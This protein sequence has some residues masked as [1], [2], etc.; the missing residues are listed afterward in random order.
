ML[1]TLL[2]AAGAFFVGARVVGARP[3]ASE[4][5]LGLD[6]GERT[7]D[8][9]VDR[10][11]VLSGASL[12]LAAGAV[13]V[14]ALWVGSAGLSLALCVPLCGRAWHALVVERRLRAAVLD[15]VSVVSSLIVGS[16]VLAAT[17]L[18]VIFGADHLQNRTEFRARRGLRA[19]DRPTRAWLRYGGADIEVPVAEL[20]PG[21]R[22]IVDAGEV[23]PIDGVVREGAAQV[24]ERMWT[25]ESLHIERGPG[26]PVFAGTRVVHGRVT[27]EVTRAGAHAPVSAP[28]ATDDERVRAEPRGDRMADAAVKPT[29]AVAGLAGLVGGG[30]SLSAAFNSNY[31]DNMQ[32]AVPLALLRA[33]RRAIDRHILV[34]D[35]RAFDLLAAV[36]A[37]VVDAQGGSADLFAPP[38]DR[39]VAVHRGAADPAGQVDRLRAEGRR[40]CYVGADAAALRRADVAVGLRDAS[41]G[42]PEA[43]HVVLM[44]GDL[45]ELPALFDLV[46]DYDAGV[47]RGVAINLACTVVAGGGVL[48]MRLGTTGVLALYNLSLALSAV[49]AY[50]PTPR[51]GQALAGPYAATR[52]AAAAQVVPA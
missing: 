12:G 37:V 28:D 25:G 40:V 52:D 50:I 10:A 6:D 48:L 51:R 14:P 22:V 4:Q 43:A 41:A 33:H 42:A 34:K 31:I 18:V 23:I 20:R 9:N 49:N 15:L 36:D 2:L 7:G 24:D 38:G 1:L 19:L 29:L 17:S 13:V 8:A 46:R 3:F 5:D 16:L 32:V 35:C 44:R 11:L 39:A 45:R 47:R 30:G 26:A 21:D 27:L